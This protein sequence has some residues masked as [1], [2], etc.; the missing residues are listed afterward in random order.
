MEKFSDE[1]ISRF[2]NLTKDKVNS[3][4]IE[5]FINKTE[6]YFNKFYLTKSS[7]V[8]LLRILE[9]QFQLN[10][11][12]SDLIRFDHYI[13]ILLTIANYSNYLTDI[14]VQTPSLFYWIT[15]PQ[16]LQQKISTKYFNAEIKKMDSTFNNFN[17]KVNFL[18]YLKKR[19]ILRIGIFD[20]YLNYSITEITKLL[21]LLALSITKY[22][23]RLCLDEIKKKY[24]IKKLPNYCLVSLGKLG[25]LELNYSSDVDLMLF[26]E[27][28]VKLKNLNINTNKIFEEAVKLFINTSSQVTNQGILYRID[29]RLRPF[30]RNSE[31]VNT[32]SNYLYYYENQSEHWE[33]QMLIKCS[34]LSGSKHLYNR[35]HNY[36]QN[37]IYPKTF[38][39]SPIQKLK[40]LKL[41]IENKNNIENNIKLSSGGIRDIEFAI[42]AL[43]LLNGGK[44]S[45]LRQKNTLTAIKKLYKNNL[46]TKEEFNNLYSNY[47]LFRK[48]EHFLQ[49]MNNLQTH[50]I[51]EDGEILGKISFILDYENIEKFKEDLRKR[52]LFNANFFNQITDIDSSRKKFDEIKFKDKKKA[53]LN[54]NYLL[55]GSIQ[56]DQKKFDELTSTSFSLIVEDLLKYLNE[57]KNPDS[58]LENFVKLIKSSLFPKYWYDIF[59]DNIILDTTLSICENS[60]FLLRELL[61]S[62]E[63]KD[64]LISKRC[65]TKFE[66]DYLCNFGTN[67]FKFISVFQLFFGVIDTKQ[68]SEVNTKYFLERIQ[69]IIRREKLDIKYGEDLI[70][71]GCGSFASEEMTLFSDIDLI[72]LVNDL[73]K[74]PSAQY[75]LQ[76]L[77]NNLKSE[78]Q[79]E[80][81]C[82][83]RPEGKSSQLVWNFED[84]IK[85]IKTRAR[86]WEFHSLTKSRIV[87]GQEKFL[88]NIHQA[89]IEKLKSVDLKFVKKELLEIRDKL[90]SNNPYWIDIKKTKGGKTDL[91]FIIGYLVLKNSIQNSQILKLKTYEKLEFL[92]NLISSK[93]VIDK[94]TNNYFFISKVEIFYQIITGNKSIKINLDDDSL[95]YLSKKLNFNSKE[96]FYNQLNKSLKEINN[97][98]I[99]TFS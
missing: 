46:L 13:E 7:E 88:E 18:K 58:T 50:L 5:K 9:N 19:E 97:L 69:K 37:I 12:I 80:V 45:E 20:Y 95:N 78:L 56:L 33:K 30:G 2:F 73:M 68:F 75:D 3:Q 54:F 29:F 83:L 16:T 23:F 84:Y 65:F 93:D 41:S 24:S 31:L 26:T 28:D 17:S 98:F 36:I 87:F 15:N 77:L 66:L 53:D 34:Y 96:E 60:N 44:N 40:Q 85:Y 4:L 89:I 32:I 14:L 70:I 27:K 57:C 49:L 38:L 71:I 11:F 48:I 72:F 99:E 51:P 63:A 82:R 42:Q 47:I 67:L 8:N 86:F 92:Y 39:I 21:S 90:V 35:F 76:K 74:Y 64:F 62:K 91:N 81:D 10:L 1:F 25:G 55:T 94:L 43:E 61:V 6:S 52:K 22:L 79:I 59:S